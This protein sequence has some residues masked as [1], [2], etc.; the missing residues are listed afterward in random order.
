MAPPGV[1]RRGLSL[2]PGSIWRAWRHWRRTR[3][4][5]GGLLI[6][7]G[8]A[9]I[10]LSERLPIRI[11]LHIGPEGVAGFL[12]PIVMIVCGFLLWFNPSQRLFYAI[13]AVLLS[14]GSWITSNLGGFIIGMLLGVVGA[15][16]AFGWTPG[17]RRSRRAET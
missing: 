9:E 5:W 1:P 15:S 7:L 17:G 16:L 14:L 6:L 2:T 13:V 4:F 11:L 8:G 3:P 10:L 12:I